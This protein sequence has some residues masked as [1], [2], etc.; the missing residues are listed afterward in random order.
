MCLQSLYQLRKADKDSAE[1]QKRLLFPSYMMQF[2]ISDKLCGGHGQRQIPE[3]YTSQDTLGWLHHSL[4]NVKPHRL[5]CFQE[6]V[7]YYRTSRSWHFWP[8][9]F[10]GKSIPFHTPALTQPVTQMK[11]WRELRSEHAILTDTPL[12][13]HREETNW[14]PVSGDSKG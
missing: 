6:L 3:T 10:R 11:S 13:K 7:F 2:L 14:N 9:C 1:R 4:S 5:C 12:P 8:N